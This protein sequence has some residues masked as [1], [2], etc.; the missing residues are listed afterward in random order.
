[1]K[2]RSQLLISYVF[3]ALLPVSLAMGAALF[4]SLN[5][6]QKLQIESMLLSIETSAESMSQYFTQRISEI[7]FYSEHEDVR[8]MDFNK[9]RPFLM[10][11]HG[12]LLYTSPSPRD[13]G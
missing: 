8:S 6:A 1:M 5:Q 10:Q 4:H 2:I 12:C 7:S 3:I 11:Q 13:R 9:M